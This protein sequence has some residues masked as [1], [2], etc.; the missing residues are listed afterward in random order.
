MIDLY[1][2]THEEQNDKDSK[3]RNKIAKKIAKS[4]R[5]NYEFKYMTE[6]IGRGLNREL[7]IL[8]IVYEDTQEITT[9]TSRKVIERTI[10]DHNENYFKKAKMS[11]A[12]NDEINENLKYETIR[13][14]I[15][16]GELTLDDCD[17][18]NVCEFLNLVAKNAKN[19]VTIF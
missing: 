1:Q 2:G 18:E 10:I 12:H 13:D 7:S 5:R 3:I 16:R 15:L 17:D 11:R 8:D 6:N 14:K 9:I 4:E 19:E